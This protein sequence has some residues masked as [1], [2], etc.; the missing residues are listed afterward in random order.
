MQVKLYYKTSS[1]IKL[2]SESVFKL[3][4]FLRYLKWKKLTGIDNKYMTPITKR[5]LKV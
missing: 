1:E 5:V 4:L 3:C 2:S